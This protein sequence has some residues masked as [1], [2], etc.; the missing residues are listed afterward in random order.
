M[1]SNQA[2]SSALREKGIAAVNQPV[3]ASG[4]EPAPAPAVLHP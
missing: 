3:T 4:A 2:A 1:N